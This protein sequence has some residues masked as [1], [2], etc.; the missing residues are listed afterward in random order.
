MTALYTEIDT[1]I[2]GGETE[3]LKAYE[4]LQN[5]KTKVFVCVKM[6]TLWSHIF[7]I[8]TFTICHIFRRV[9]QN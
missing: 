7:Q 4:L 5:N 3:K 6:E 1:F 8:Y 2:D 9:E